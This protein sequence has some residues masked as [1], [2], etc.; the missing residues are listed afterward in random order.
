MVA[1]TVMT[2]LTKEDTAEIFRIQL[3][4][5]TDVTKLVPF[6]LALRVF[7]STER[8]V[9]V[10]QLNETKMTINNFTFFIH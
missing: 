2:K 9:L 4:A 1:L 6:A 5:V 8:N 3:D 10:S 7:N